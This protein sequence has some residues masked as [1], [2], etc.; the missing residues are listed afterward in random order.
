MAVSRKKVK[1][2]RLGKISNK[3][4]DNTDNDSENSSK[5]KVSNNIN[6]EKG[7]KRYF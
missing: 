5:I 3:D 7:T 6:S 1:I 4:V 2:S